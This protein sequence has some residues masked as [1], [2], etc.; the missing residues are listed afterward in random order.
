MFV[1]I[2]S[3]TFKAMK[4]E[5]LCGHVHRA[6]VP[7]DTI[8]IKLR[9]ISSIVYLEGRKLQKSTNFSFSYSILFH[10][11][12]LSFSLWFH[13]H[14]FHNS[15]HLLLMIYLNSAFSLILSLSF[16]LPCFALLL[17]FP[18]AE[19]EPTIINLPLYCFWGERTR[20]R[21]K[22]GGTWEM[23]EK[24]KREEKGWRNI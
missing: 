17:H 11:T 5:F 15:Y 12:F 16:S 19:K 7:Y 4:A 13:F 3:T 6:S 21:G 22:G 18:Q 1:R 24:K 20:E 8:P 10:S 2:I 23:Q 14:L 9:K